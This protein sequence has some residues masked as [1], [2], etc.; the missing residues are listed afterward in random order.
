MKATL[1]LP[2]KADARFPGVGKTQPQGTE[3]APGPAHAAAPGVAGA[4]RVG[5]SS[6]QAEGW[7]RRSLPTVRDPSCRPWGAPGL[8][9]LAEG[10]IGLK[11]GVQGGLPALGFALQGALPHQGTVPQLLRDRGPQAGR[12]T[13]APPGSP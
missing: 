12:P 2:T 9:P 4:R 3:G 13:S 6:G 11:V 8:S 10:W 7:S 5:V 1:C